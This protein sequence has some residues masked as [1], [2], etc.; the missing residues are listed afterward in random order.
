MPYWYLPL[1]CP[2]CRSGIVSLSPFDAKDVVVDRCP[3]CKGFW[4][5]AG[6]L[7]KMQDVAALLDDRK[8]LHLSHY[9]RPPEW[10]HLCWII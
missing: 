10:S 7:E 9:Q 6:D 8:L 4:L 2:K 5:N 3:I 1:A